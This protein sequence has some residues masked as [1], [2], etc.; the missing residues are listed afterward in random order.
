MRTE[1]SNA[2]NRLADPG[3]GARFAPA[4][5]RACGVLLCCASPALADDWYVD[6]AHGDDANGGTSAADAW[7]TITHALA[8]APAPAPGAT[9]TLH[10]APGLYDAALGESFPI[11]LRDAFRLVGDEGR[12]VT[13]IDAGGASTVM[14]ASAGQ[15]GGNWTGPLTLVS[16][17]S[18]ENGV[19]GIS[20][21][22]GTGP[23]YLTVEDCRIFAMSE[24]GFHTSAGCFHT[25]GKTV[26]TLAR[27]E[28]IGC[29][30]GV[31]FGSSVASASN[32]TS[33]L[34]LVDCLINGSSFHGIQQFDAG[35]GTDL[36]LLRTRIHYSG[37]EALWVVQDDWG[38]GADTHATLIDCLIA[39][40]ASDGV[41]A[42]LLHDNISQSSVRIDVARTTIADN[43]YGLE[44]FH[45]TGFMPT[46]AVTL[47]DS[48]VD[49]NYDDI[50]ENPAHP[51]ITSVSH[52][53]IGDGD[54]AGTNGNF[55][56]DPMFVDA[57]G[58]DY[59]L[60][61]GSPCIEA[62]DR[63][64]APGGIDLAHNPR[65]IDGDLD[66]VERPDVGAYEFAPLF[67]NSTGAIGTP[68]S[69][70]LWGPQDNASTLYFSRLP[71]VSPSMTQ[72]GELDLD[73]AS[74]GVF[75]VTTVGSG[76]PRIVTRTIPYQL[77][78]IGQTFSFQAL[79][80]CSAA[81]PGMAYTNAVEITLVP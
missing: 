51:S 4:I 25:C 32:V 21:A 65:P 24:A 47:T 74:M 46:L 20:L 52:C 13:R 6:A 58:N 27:V 8:T 66:T 28:L 11:L 49:H 33:T 9:Q 17:L 61:W 73:P 81:A 54:F 19:D 36:L 10:V 53:D 67:L 37:G 30:I 70:E 79:T 62:G 40:N 44:V 55:A 1:E 34:A 63:T 26:A 38:V 50:F 71:L 14:S 35:G 7:K 69:F 23:I 77:G 3:L 76:R 68:L 41:K 60:R 2:A 29:G 59:R 57:P 43:F 22:T 31:D 42:E 16:G 45:Q 80:D 72:F 39:N 12:D 15:F 64:T 75:R 18:L 48:I 78:L 5:A 56:A